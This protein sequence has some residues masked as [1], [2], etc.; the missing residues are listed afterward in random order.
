M[1]LLAQNFQKH[2][3]VKKNTLFMT[4]TS[5]VHQHTFLRLYTFVVF[6]FIV[7]GVLQVAV[8]SVITDSAICLAGCFMEIVVGLNHPNN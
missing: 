4:F 3:K 5:L 8:T 2:L 6:L 7:T 1:L